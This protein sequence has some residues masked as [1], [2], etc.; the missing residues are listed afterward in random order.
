[1]TFMREGSARVSTPIEKLPG[2]SRKHFQSLSL[3]RVMFGLVLG[4]SS[5]WLCLP[6]ISGNGSDSVTSGLPVIQDE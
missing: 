1:M 5:V 2:N 6:A 3:S 4:F